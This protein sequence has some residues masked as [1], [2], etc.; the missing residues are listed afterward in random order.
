MKK[1]FLQILIVLL[2]IGIAWGLF[3][4]G[5]KDDNLPIQATINQTAGDANTKISLE[6][7]PMR[8]WS[9]DDPEISA[10]AAII[11]NFGQN[12]KENILYQNNIN[13]PL[14]IASLTKLMT[15]IITLENYDLNKIIQVSE[16][17]IAEDGNNGGL[18]VGEE[19][20]V[21]DLLY[22]ML[23]ESSNDAA[24]ALANDNPEMPYDEFIELMNDKARELNMQNTNFI[25]PAGLSPENKSTILDM[26]KLTEYT[27]NLPVIMQI[28]QTPEIS[29][30]SIDR[31]FIH[32]LITTD[33]L[34][35]KIPR[36]IGGKTGFTD[37][38]GGCM[39]TISNVYG[40]RVE[41]NNYL[42]TVVLGS[43]NREDDTQKLIE[44]SQNA[45]I[46]K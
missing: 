31:K 15:A 5:K 10:K 32:N 22:I 44:W 18:I 3:L 23:I 14:P 37:E 35:G 4:I 21:H 36:L 34:L 27:L 9:V 40:E 26:A 45:W 12:S 42:I 8:N 33:K 41:S 7:Y 19:L 39:I 28:I 30:Y 43:N 38:A 16:N 11:L 2:L 46:W 25:E 6:L 20:K 24:M 13:E 29:I 1:Y 17:S